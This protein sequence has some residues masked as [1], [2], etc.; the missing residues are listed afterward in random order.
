MKNGITKTLMFSTIPY[1]QNSTSAIIRFLQYN[2]FSN[3]KELM[4]K[5]QERAR[6]DKSKAEYEAS[7]LGS[8]AFRNPA[9]STN[10]QDSSKYAN[11]SGESFGTVTAGDIA[12][13]RNSA[14]H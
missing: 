11:R 10:L 8:G 14:I 3:L 6:R 7:M 9:M 2:S 12:R 13:H 4:Q 5:V 1:A